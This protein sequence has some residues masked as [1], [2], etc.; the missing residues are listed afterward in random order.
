[1]TL[2][3]AKE[4]ATFSCPIARVSGEDP[5]DPQCRGDKCMFWRW[6]PIAADDPRVLSAITREIAILRG[7]AGNEKKA[8]PT[9]RKEAIARV[10]KDPKA[11]TFPTDRDKGWCGLAGRPE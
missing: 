3:T 9:L 7:E 4:A 5:V 1:M 10:S 6:V 11:F 8:E 2:R